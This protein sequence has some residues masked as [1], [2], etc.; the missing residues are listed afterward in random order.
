MMTVV[1]ENLSFEALGTFAY[2]LSP[3][4]A[5]IQEVAELEFYRESDQL[6]RT[7]SQG[8]VRINIA[9]WENNPTDIENNFV[10]YQEAV[11]INVKAKDEEEALH[12]L[13]IQ[14]NEVNL[15]DAYITLY[16][17]EGKPYLFSIFQTRINWDSAEINLKN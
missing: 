10:H 6:L 15:N 2:S 11:I 14:V 9:D 13:N 17:F 16:D 8:A 5:S 3:V 7:K 1:N 12:M 4:S